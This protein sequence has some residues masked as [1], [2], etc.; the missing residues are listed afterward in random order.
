[1][2]T[3]CFPVFA[4]L[5]FACVQTGARTP[6]QTNKSISPPIPPERSEAAGARASRAAQQ[7]LKQGQFPKAIV[8]LRLANAIAKERRPGSLTEGITAAQLAGALMDAGNYTDALPFFEEATRTLTKVLPHN[9][10]NLI[11]LINQHAQCLREASKNDSAYRVLRS[12]FAQARTERFALPAEVVAHANDFAIQL[13]QSGDIISSAMLHEDVIEKLEKSDVPQGHVSIARSNLALLFEKAELPDQELAA[14]RPLTK[15]GFVSDKEHCNT[16][17]RVTSAALRAGLADEAHAYLDEAWACWT[18]AY[19]DFLRWVS[20]QFSRLGRT[21]VSHRTVERFLSE[22]KLDSD[23]KVGFLYTASV[24]YLVEQDAC[25]AAAMSQRAVALLQNQKPEQASTIKVYELAKTARELCNRAKDQ[26]SVSRKIAKENEANLEELRA[27]LAKAE[28]SYHTGSPSVTARRSNLAIEL[29]KLGHKAEA[30]KEASRAGKDFTTRWMSSSAELSRIAQLSQQRYIVVHMIDLIVSACLGLS[31]ESIE[32]L[33]FTKGHILEGI[34]QEANLLRLSKGR[35]RETTLRLRALR[36]RIAAYLLAERAPGLRGAIETKEKLER[37]LTDP[38]TNSIAVEPLGLIG[39][40]EGLRRSLLEDEVYID[41]TTYES[42]LN[43]VRSRRIAAII[44]MRDTTM[45]VDVGSEKVVRRAHSKW[46]SAIANWRAGGQKQLKHLRSLLIDP[47]VAKI[48]A[49]IHNVIISSD[50]ELLNLP[51]QHP[52]F[53]RNRTVWLV[54]SARELVRYKLAA[55]SSRPPIAGRMAVLHNIDFNAGSG[56]LV[57]PIARLNK[58]R[59]SDKVQSRAGIHPVPKVSFDDV[60]GALTTRKRLFEVLAQSEAFHIETH[61]LVLEADQARNLQ[62]SPFSAA[63]LALAGSNRRDSRGRRAGLVS[64]EEL[65]GAINPRIRIATLAMC[66]SARG[67]SIPGQGNLG[68]ATAFMTAGT[69]IVVASAWRSS[70]QSAMALFPAFYNR[71]F[72][73][74]NARAAFDKGIDALRRT[75]NLRGARHWAGW[76]YL[77]YDRESESPTLQVSR[78]ANQLCNCRS[79]KC[80]WKDPAVLG[81]LKKILAAPELST[82]DKSLILRLL[83][84]LKQCLPESVAPKSK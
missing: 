55:S 39:G 31:E 28:Q 2:T 19:I 17:A 34:R 69:P 84:N 63:A 60:S 74:G 16:W 1:M 44:L 81:E 12:L 50:R 38:G 47:L 24:A 61:G 54:G 80:G 26:R 35:Q 53:V 29:L 72:V 23:A 6:R 10:R 40:I 76:L 15:L 62:R 27:D 8:Q 58:L 45:W 73:G 13:G 43:D 18:T 25:R 32:A 42:F 68:L 20:F 3:R 46:K 9:D 49:S 64:A 71:L 67:A 52:D 36:A 11:L 7:L 82:D 14:L 83:S 59:P 48:P 77:G 65:V 30:C 75:R 66:D 22:Q 57:E 37:K 51:W 5:L 4:F 79:T 33:F 21:G 41:F 70:L 56:K 78:I